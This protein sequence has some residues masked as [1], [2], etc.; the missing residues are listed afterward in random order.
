MK[1]KASL[2]A[3]LVASAPFAFA[4]DVEVATDPV[5]Y[6]SVNL[7]A[8][9]DTRISVP[10]HRAP[11]FQG[12]P[13][14]VNGSSINFAEGTG[15][16]P[17]APAYFI[18]VRSGALAG[19]RATVV[20]VDNGGDTLIIEEGVD[21]SGL[22]TGEGGDPI[23]LIP[24]WTLSTLFPS[25]LSDETEVFVFDRGEPGV[26]LAPS[27][28]FINFGPDWFD[29]GT[30]EEAD[31]V[32][33]SP[34]E[35]IIIRDSSGSSFSLVM[36]GSVPMFPVRDAMSTVA[37]NTAQDISVGFAVP[38]NVRLGDIQGAQEGDELFLPAN[39]EPGIDKAPERIFVNFGG[40]WFDGGTFE[41]ADNVEV[42]PG[43]GFI[44]RK[45][46]TSE[47]QSDAITLVPSYLSSN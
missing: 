36:A 23:Q 2:L 37:A 27:R 29:S 31:D 40:E 7:T 34:D 35:S 41:E 32:V 12:I 39:E 1:I 19:T 14:S 47:P 5:G 28:I 30:F 11:V 15:I 18:A 20:G 9:S 44:F 13:V 22:S 16:Q 43:V 45:A 25:N 46:A 38:S 10:M 33:I 21:L 42:T 6:V 3:G 24:H 4:Q 17:E 26:D 8:A